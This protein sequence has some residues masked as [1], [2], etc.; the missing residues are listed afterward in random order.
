MWSCERTRSRVC[1]ESI[2]GGSG[3]SPV[4]LLCSG[5]ELE[6]NWPT[7]T[8]CGLAVRKSWIQSQSELLRPR[9]ESLTASL[10]GTIVLKAEH[11]VRSLVLI[12]F[13]LLYCGGCDSSLYDT[14]ALCSV[15][16]T[17]YIDS[18]AVPNTVTNECVLSV[19][20]DYRINTPR[21]QGGLGHMK[22][23]LVADS[24]RSISRDYGGAEGRWGY[25]IQ[26]WGDY[27]IQTEDWK[28]NHIYCQWKVWVSIDIF[29]S[30][31]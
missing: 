11:Q 30:Q 23:P 6:V 20:D 15:N 10:V 25:C 27:F 19:C 18:H 26:V 28:S 2:A 16:S 8:T 24:L 4:G 29:W 3:H 21:K 22:V 17:L 1:R 13:V 31:E 9:S 12:N 5:D 14:P 7:F